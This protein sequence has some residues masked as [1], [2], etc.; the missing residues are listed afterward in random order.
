MKNTIKFYALP[1]ILPAILFIFT[2]K[3][4]AQTGNEILIV[5]DRKVQS[6]TDQTA[7]CLA[8]KRLNE[9]KFTPLCQIIENFKYLPEYFYV[10]DVSVLPATTTDKKYRLKKILAQVKS[11]NVSA[12]KNPASSLFG[13]KWKLLK[14]NGENVGQTKAFI[15]FDERKNSVGGNGGC[16]SFGGQLLKNGAKL[17]ISQIF[18]TKMFCQ[19]GSEIENKLFVNIEKI[20]DY[21]ISENRLILKS[22]TAGLLEFV[23][24]NGN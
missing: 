14:I 16:N 24:Q 3:M 11:E 13:A 4:A 7:N 17:K 10:L 2:V 5:A 12:P 20:T 23:R 19:Q 22:N 6:A 15:V 18:S 9:E 8:V 21:A 1:I